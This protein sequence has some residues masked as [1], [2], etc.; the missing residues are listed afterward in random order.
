M[1]F[2]REDHHR[3]PGHLVKARGESVVAVVF[4]GVVA[5]HRRRPPELVHP[6]EA[7]QV[8]VACRLGENLDDSNLLERNTVADV[9]SQLNVDQV[10]GIEPDDPL[11]AP[12]EV[13]AENEAL[14][15]GDVPPA[16]PRG[17][18]QE[19][20]DADDVVAV[21]YCVASRASLVRR[22]LSKA[23]GTNLPRRWSLSPLNYPCRLQLSRVEHSISNSLRWLDVEGGLHISRVF[24]L[25]HIVRGIIQGAPMEGSAWK[26]RHCR[27]TRCYP[28]LPG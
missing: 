14:L 17:V 5:D 1:V 20:I 26:T 12:S 6:L 28:P 16:G 9:W 25:A 4:V 10:V 18:I 22:P 21:T 19:S 13:L 2:R 27:G 24:L 11:V 3:I 8:P 7:L 23:A 15:P